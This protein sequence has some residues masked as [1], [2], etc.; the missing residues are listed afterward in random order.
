[1]PLPPGWTNEALVEEVVHSP[2]RGRIQLPDTRFVER[3]GWR[4]LLTPSL[5]QGGLN[6]V[7]ASLDAADADRVIDETIDEYRRLGLRFR[8]TVTPGSKPDDLGERLARRGLKPHWVHGVVR[9]LSPVKARDAAVEA[10]GL[11]TVDEFTGVMAAGWE[12]DPATL[13]VLHRTMLECHPDRYRLFLAREG[14]RAIGVAS[15]TVATPA[16]YLMGAVVLPAFRGRGVYQALVATR[17]ADAASRGLTLG[18]SQ[19][20]ADTSAPILAKLGFE[21]VCRFPVYQP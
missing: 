17:I 9:D 13:D 20:R 19:A 7:D 15:Y 2:W 8:W 18:T 16:A 3:P 12:M 4:Q 1:M 5:K 11:A 14:T 10:V 6:E 21:T